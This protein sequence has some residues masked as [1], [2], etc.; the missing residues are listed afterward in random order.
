VPAVH[1]DSV[2][3]SY[4]SAV[5]VL[6]DVDLHLGP[7][8]TGVV[9]PNGAGKSTLL[10]LVA[11]MLPPSSGSVRC[12][13]AD[14]KPVLCPQEVEAVTPDIDGLAARWD[15][16]AHRW[17][18]LLGL[19]PAQLSRWP[20][21]SP[22]ERK[23]WQVGAALAAEPAVLL[24][25]E[26]TNHLDA[27]AAALVREA[28]EAFDGIGLMVSH[29]RG[30]LAGLTR[31]TIRVHGGRA[32]LWNG[33]YGVARAGWEAEAQEVLGARAAIERE[34]HKVERRIADR[35][36]AAEAKRAR[37]RRSLHSD[38]PIDPDARS[39]ARRG[40]FDAGDA[41]G[42]RALA[43]DRA[44]ATRLAAEA[45]ALTVERE[46]G[47]SLFVDYRPARKRV[48]VGYRGDLT[49]GS[50]VLVPG[51]D[52]AVGREDRI[53]LTGPNG[54]GKSTLLRALLDAGRDTGSL[55]ADRVLHLPQELTG[56]AAVRRIDR[57][58]ALPPDARG[59]VLSVVAALGV[60]PDRLLASDA[61]SPGEARKASLAFGLGVGVWC[62]LLDEP[63]NH[64][65]LPSIERL[66]DAVVDYPGALVLVTHDEAFAAAAT[67][68][69]WRL[70]GT[71]L[72]VGRDRA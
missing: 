21:L 23:R 27:G 43:K 70:E 16:A 28:L 24:L 14:P 40:R 65:D 49:A 41:A 6:I 17:R 34:R 54:S 22:G 53:R 51:I 15:R 5:D 25:D 19:D 61:P 71:S 69:E 42:G 66:E 59:R 60:D 33:P 63:T 46:R 57:I 1:L 12:E 30:L 62:L 68:T 10:R 37:Y 35:R 50:R 7:G 4:S 20:S 39:A 72:L 67:S 48:L 2:S 58:R 64:L 45:A 56:D 18:G 32:D 9:G 3:F 31:Q 55:P 38:T 13:P 44:V 36:R 11:G 29:D 26:P 52:V 47:R 8:W